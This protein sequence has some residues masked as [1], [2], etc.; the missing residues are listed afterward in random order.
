MN[1]LQLYKS[2]SDAAFNTLNIEAASDVDISAA[3]AAK[4]AEIKDIDYPMW[5]QY[6][7]ACRSSFVSLS[8]QPAPSAA[9]SAAIQNAKQPVP[10][11]AMKA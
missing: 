8:K 9:P 7:T 4:L 11:P 1:R 2:A 6:F 10:A 3:N 5:K